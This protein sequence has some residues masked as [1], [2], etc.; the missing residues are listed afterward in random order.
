M[1]A[2]I[3][4][5]LT[6]FFVSFSSCK[7]K[8]EYPKNTD[9]SLTWLSI[10][11]ASELKNIDE[12]LYFVDVYTSWCK[13]CKVMD[14]QTFTEASVIKLLDEQFHVVKF[15]AEQTDIVNWNGVEYLYQAGGRRGIHTLAP[16][17]LKGRLSYPSFAVLD[18]DRNPI[19]IIVGFK[20]PEQLIR[21]LQGL[22]S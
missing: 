3:L 16:H 11:E 10:D 15:N 4:L 17:L 7:E 21:E 2:R 6:L 14:Q 5:F 19:K 1:N 22:K 18:K 20:K 8:A 12:K 13:W 9:G